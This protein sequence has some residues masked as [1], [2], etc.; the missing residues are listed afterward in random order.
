MRVTVGDGRN[1]ISFLSPT[2]R[3]DTF[4][5][6]LILNIHFKVLLPF[7]KYFYTLFSTLKEILCMDIIVT[8]AL[9]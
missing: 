8:M 7:I 9:P 4:Q 5:I 2:S 1:K 3:K 6:A